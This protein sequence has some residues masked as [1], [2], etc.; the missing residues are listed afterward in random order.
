[1]THI[2]LVLLPQPVEVVLQLLYSIARQGLWKC[3]QKGCKLSLS[4]TQI[5]E[6]KQGILHGF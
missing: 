2:E 4:Q 6:H 3:L 5:L 1:M